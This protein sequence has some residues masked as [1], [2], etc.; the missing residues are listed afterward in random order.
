M[1]ADLGGGT[2]SSAAA[3]EIYA[4]GGAVDDRRRANFVSRQKMIVERMAAKACFVI[5]G[6]DAADH[7]SKLD[8][9]HDLFV[10]TQDVL[11]NGDSGLE[12][13]P[14]KNERVLAS[15]DEIDR[16]FRPFDAAALSI[17][18]GGREPALLE[19][20]IQGT[21][22]LETA[23]DRLAIL[24]DRIYVKDHYPLPVLNQLEVAGEQRWLSQ[25]VVREACMMGTGGDP[26][27]Y[28]VRLEDTAKLFD[29]RLAALTDGQILIG[30]PAPQTP[31]LVAILSR[32][33]E[34]WT[35]MRRPIDAAVAAGEMSPENLREIVKHSTPLMTAANEAVFLVEGQN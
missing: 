3:E 15:L 21:S 7:G 26:V 23:L 19:V 10:A 25:K 16:R 2:V 20:K 6:F 8:A 34:I 22:G 35:A 4:I 28:R 24:I 17:R 1:L 11:R 9:A 29:A 14:E 18:D 31:E 30:L 32:V 33:S 5:N 27:L 13:K 12:L